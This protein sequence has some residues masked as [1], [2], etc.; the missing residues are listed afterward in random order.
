MNRKK[1]LAWQ[2]PAL[3]I[4]II[5]TVIVA[6][7]QQAMPYQHDEGMVFG[8]FYSITYQHDKNLKKEIEAQLQKVDNSLSP[9]NKKSIISAINRNENVE[10]DQMFLNVFDLAKQI[11]KDTDGAFDITVAPLV[12]LWGFGFKNDCPP[13]REAVDSL[14]RFI[15]LEKVSLAG[16]TIRKT[17]PDVMLDCSAIAKGYGVDVVGRYLASL[18]IKN[19]MVDIGGEIVAKG[20]S[21]KSLPW[22]IGVEKP[23]DD[24]L[25]VK[26]ELQTVLN[27]TD[28]AMATSGNYRNFYYK[29]GKKYAHTIDPKTGF[30]VQHNI[31]S[32]TVL[33]NECAR[34]DAYATAFMVMG[35]EKAKDVLARNKDLKAY[36]IYDDNGKYKVWKSEGLE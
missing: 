32:A 36:I 14:R 16:K 10:I 19:F 30:P 22:K 15:G 11:N 26:K 34:A 27:I 2:L 35:L 9:F 18:G 12:N 21:P 1:R 17:S 28:I 8:T 6:R 25:A 3:L 5:G 20:K 7:Q 13:T 24:S 33:A 23:V 31:L 29:D 4:L